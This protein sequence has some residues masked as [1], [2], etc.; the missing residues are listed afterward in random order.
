MI[1]LLLILAQITP[2]TP[3]SDALMQIVAWLSGPGFAAVISSALEAWPKFHA[4]PK[5]LK[6]IFSTIL[7]ALGTIFGYLLGSSSTIAAIPANNPAIAAALVGVVFLFIQFYH[8][9][10]K[11]QTAILPPPK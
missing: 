3:F 4:M 11:T 7:T 8:A 1:A 2:T 9:Q 6:F 5:E 10:T